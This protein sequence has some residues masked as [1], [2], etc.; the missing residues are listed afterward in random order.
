M[1]S[2][3]SSSRWR[4]TAPFWTSG[5]RTA[6]TRSVSPTAG[7]PPTAS[8]A[9]ASLPPDKPCWPTSRTTTS[10]SGR[11]PISSS[12]TSATRTQPTTTAP[13]PCQK[14]LSSEPSTTA[15]EASTP[16]VKHSS[17]AWTSKAILSYEI[18]RPV[19]R[20]S[21]RRSSVNGLFTTRHRAIL[22]SLSNHL[23]D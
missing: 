17:S 6:P 10:P 23:R 7:S 21:A 22:E 15:P 9:H 20:A 13:D 1:T 3:P 16:A 5:S 14:S 4:R 11:T 12:T 8:G 18:F 2:T 19:R